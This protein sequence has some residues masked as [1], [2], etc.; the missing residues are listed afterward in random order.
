[1]TTPFP[2]YPGL[3]SP[4]TWTTLAQIKAPQLRGDVSDAVQLLSQPPFFAGQNSVNA[5]S[6]STAGAVNPVPLDSEIADPW[7]GHVTGTSGNPN[8]PRW[9]APFAG[10]YLV[11]V[12]V[13]VTMP[14]G[15]AA[16]QYTSAG[17]QRVTGGG[18]TITSA[19]QIIPGP[20]SGTHVA[21]TMTKL[22]AQT[23]IGS[24]YIAPT[25]QVQSTNAIN[26]TISANGNPTIN[27]Q[28][29]CASTGTQPLPVPINDNWAVPPAIITHQF[30]NTNVRDTINFL[31]YPPIMEWTY[32]NATNTLASASSLPTVGT[33]IGLDTQQVDNYSAFNNTTNIWAAPVAG[34]YLLYGELALTADVN[35][36]AMAVGLTVTSANYNG[37]TQ[38]TW[39]GDA[40]LTPV[41]AGGFTTI[42]ACT[43][44]KLRLNAGD[45]I[46]LAGW[47]R[48]SAA[49]AYTILGTGN[50]NT[51]LGIVWQS[52]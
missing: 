42:A 25:V 10:W 1:M 38:F 35:T 40:M 33:L 29:V 36:Q 2:A 22:I 27:I 52:A 7:A 47:Q 50:W 49:G 31:I 4:I 3:P 30:M 34:V 23:S 11:H 46:N 18:A 48:N 43:R 16:A 37:G 21:P 24:D 9:F 41:P 39:W 13:P 8:N 51:R 17:V 44:R 26:T 45:K 6:L 14:S 5:F 19:G 32:A 28:W 15:T 20:F 12:T